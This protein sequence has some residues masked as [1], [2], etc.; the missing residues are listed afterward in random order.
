MIYI[1]VCFLAGCAI[2][3]A[4]FPDL[5]R[6]ALRAYDG[7]PLAIT[8]YFVML[9]AW[10]L[11]GTLAVTWLTYFAAYFFRGNE[12][13]LKYAN[14]IVMPL[15]LLLSSVF[16]YK[17]RAVLREEKENGTVP[18]DNIL[19][20]LTVTL[21]AASLMWTTFFVSGSNLYVGPSVYSDFSPHLGMIRSFSKGNNFP[22]QYPFFAGEDIKYHFMFQFLAGNLEFLGLRLDYAF[23]LP[24]ML[25]LI[26]AFLLLFVMA[27]KITG[28]RAAGYLACLF[29]AFRSSESLFT[30]LSELP[31]GTNI[32]RALSENTEFIG[33][34]THEEW[35]LWNLNVYCNQRH[36]AFSLSVIILAIMLFLPYL[37]AVF[38]RAQDSKPSF[39]SLFLTKDGWRVKDW[40][41]P[42]MTGLFLGTI[43]FWN[44][45]A[46]IAALAVLFI[47]AICSER[48]LEFLIIAV[49]A[50]IL[51]V[52]QAKFFIR[53]SAVTAKL[54]FGFIAENPTLFGVADYLK[55]LLGI[56][57]V[58]LF[59][60]FLAANGVKRYLMLAFSAPLVLAF[61]LSLT[62][63]VTVNHKYI[64]IAVMFLG[65]FAADFLIRLFIKH[66]IWVKIGG[67]VIVIA[68]TATGFYDY[69]TVLHRNQSSSA[70]VLD[71]N[72]KLTEWIQD[73]SDSRDIFLTS[74]Y[75]LNR[76]V[77]GGAMLYQGWTYYAWSAGYDTA[78][79]DVQV[80]LMYEADSAGELK[81]LV[82]KNHIRYI[83]VD[84]DNRSSEAYELDEDNIKNTYSCVFRDGEGEW[85][86][87]V[88][89]TRK[90]K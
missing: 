39:R 35:G 23:N 80:K 50:V 13:P 3:T 41:T 37:Y 62:A 84:N 25:S 28:K 6:F 18:W 79:R 75:A 10:F 78:A 16:L 73:N 27:A 54:Y 29:F 81:T 44:G 14:L 60:A 61:S 12:A 1:I 40:R 9:P 65:I 7:S 66:D 11:T 30:Y 43:A 88:Y 71:L 74:N 32:L 68:L 67:T 45:A 33:Y 48:R 52:L 24:S 69:L 36:L 15:A 59:A 83:I 86:A 51:S 42:V 5:K 55:R 8:P 46:L 64:M 20:L 56:L 49:I 34:T 82:K 87:S 53:G 21:L 57:P 4:A 22:T 70:V 90:E 38:E 72:D 77:L 89:D 47:L 19:F 63:D 31:K 76:V 17:K 58:V 85:A 2:C 26:S